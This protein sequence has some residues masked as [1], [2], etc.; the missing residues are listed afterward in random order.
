MNLIDESL[1]HCNEIVNIPENEIKVMIASRK[2]NTLYNFI[3]HQ[4]SNK[5]KP[6][7]N[8]ILEYIKNESKCMNNLANL[9]SLFGSV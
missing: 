4:Q 7:V 5:I 1:N 8:E 2:I 3:I 9:L 6:M